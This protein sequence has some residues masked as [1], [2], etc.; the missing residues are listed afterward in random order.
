MQFSPGNEGIGEWRLPR[1]GGVS[2]PGLFDAWG[3]E[4]IAGIAGGEFY[5]IKCCDLFS[6]LATVLH[7]TDMMNEQT[8]REIAPALA[9]RLKRD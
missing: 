3:K 9:I 6:E 4:V 5:A 1:P 8:D 2:F 7:H